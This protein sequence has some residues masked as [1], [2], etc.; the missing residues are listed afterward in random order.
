[1]RGDVRLAKV[2]GTG[3]PDDH[4]ALDVALEI[5]A[6]EAARF[7][8]LEAQGP[9]VHAVV[10]LNPEK[11]WAKRAAP[12]SLVLKGEVPASTPDASVKAVSDA[13]TRHAQSLHRFLDQLVQLRVQHL[14][15]AASAAAGKLP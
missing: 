10:A 2:A 1:V 12:S 9:A 15:A 11:K 8:G 4:Q 3:S 13:F 5:R 7:Y 6:T 14:E